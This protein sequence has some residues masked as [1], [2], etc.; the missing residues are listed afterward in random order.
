[1]PAGDGTGPA[2]T[3]PMTGRGA[4]FCAGYNT[5]GYISGG[6]GFGRGPGRGFRFRSSRAARGWF[7][8]FRQESGTEQQALSEELS[9]LKEQMT[10]IEKRMEEIQSR[11][12]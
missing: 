7:P 4:G 5:P 1:M 3:G 9:A 10:Q 6:G 2:G 11:S 12:S 8:W